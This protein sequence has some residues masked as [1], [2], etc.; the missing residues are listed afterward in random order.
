MNKID[1]TNCKRIAKAYNGAN[2]SKIAVEYNGEVYMLK[3]PK[4]A[5]SKP[6]E[7]SYSNSNYSEHI[8]CSIFNLLGVKAQKTMLGIFHVNGKEKM[9]CA[10]KDFTSDGKSLFDFC[11]IKN[12]IIDSESNGMG[13]ELSDILEAIEK[14]IFVDPNELLKHF[15]EMFIVD[16]LL[17]NFDRHNG[18]W[19]FL[20]NDKTGEFSIAPVFDCGSCL[21]PQADEKIMKAVINDKKELDARIFTF[22]RS[23]V[24]LNDDKLNYYDFI[25][26]MENEDCNEALIRIYERIDMNRIFDFIDSEQYLSDLQ[27]EFYKTY[28]NAR[29][30]TILEPTYN[31]LMDIKETESNT[32]SDLS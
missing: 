22:P 25:S 20:K 13:T 31:A 19:G 24:K 9:V 26:S 10:G 28:I 11:S 3:F 5:E 21:L 23:A 16:A 8:S 17:G 14:Q 7:L 2:G 32:F 30:E 27:K 4:S 12:T 15:W 29:K 6:N 1:F 18:N